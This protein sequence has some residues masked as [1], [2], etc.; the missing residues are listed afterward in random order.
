MK[1]KSVFFIF[2]LG[3]C[4][5]ILGSCSE[6]YDY[7]RAEDQEQLNFSIKAKTKAL[8]DINSNV[9]S[10]YD[11]EAY[12]IYILKVIP[13]DITSID[14]L[15]IDS[16]ESLYLANL[17]DG[18]WFLFSGD[19]NNPPIIAEGDANNPCPSVFSTNTAGNNEWVKSFYHQITQNRNDITEESKTNRLLWLHARKAAISHSEKNREDT[20][21]LS[22]DYVLDTISSIIYPALTQTQWHEGSPWNSGIPK[23]RHGTSRCYAGS[24]IVALSQLLYYTHFSINKP[25]YIYGSVD[26]TYYY[27]EYPYSNYGLSN[28]TSVT[29]GNMPGTANG[30]T[31]AISYVAALYAYVAK[32]STTEYLVTN[33]STSNPSDSYSETPE[34]N[35]ALAFRHFGLMVDFD[36]GDSFNM[37]DAITEIQNN[38]PVYCYEYSSSNMINEAYLYDGYRS[39]YIKETETLTDSSG[40]IVEENI[41][42]YS[43]FNWHINSGVGAVSHYYWIT[44]TG[45][46]PNNR[47]MFVGW[48]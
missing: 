33:S 21:D 26:C 42:Y 19:Y 16:S 43:V 29:W 4:T 23:L 31:T 12:L 30:D 27:D 5:V 3:L 1:T 40:N 25:N 24:E 10:Q 35:M 22:Y 47:R 39:Y 17:K 46:N 32:I 41:N 9:I 2:L 6:L 44:N 34:L 20:L 37:S 13:T 45:N 8:L 38:R 28:T 48:N 11:V 7:P 36:Y 18:R 14:Q 15:R